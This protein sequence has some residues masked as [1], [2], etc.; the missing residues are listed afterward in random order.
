[1]TTTIGMTTIAQ[2]PRD[3]VVPFIRRYMSDDLRITECGCRDGLTWE[4]IATLG[5][6][7]PSI[8]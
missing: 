5:H 4:E 1:M 8:E 2:S 6:E 7:P 3:D